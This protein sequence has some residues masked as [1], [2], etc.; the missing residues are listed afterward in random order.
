VRSVQDVGGPGLE[1][2]SPGQ[3]VRGPAIWKR[4]GEWAG[5]PGSCA[6][7]RPGEFEAHA[8]DGPRP[9]HPAAGTRL[10]ACLGILGLPVGP[11]PLGR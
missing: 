5:Q 7:L 3:A 10:S 2:G 4:D 9:A 1:V 6:D 11:N 8:G